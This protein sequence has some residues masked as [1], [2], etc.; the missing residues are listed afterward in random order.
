MSVIFAFMKVS[1]R[2]IAQR[3]IQKIQ[4]EIK[5]DNLKLQ[6]VIISAGNDPNSQTYIRFKKE[7]AEEIGIKAT[8]LSFSENQQ[9]ECLKSIHELNAN[10]TVHGII[11]QLPLYRHW[12]IPAYIHS[13]DPQKDVD[14]FIDH[15]SFFGATALGVWEML[16]EFAAIEGFESTEKFLHGKSVVIVGKGITAGKPTIELLQK[17]GIKTTIIDSKTDH[18][19][20]ILRNSD[21]IISATGRKHI[22]HAENIK[23]GAY[24]IGVGMQKEIID[25]TEKTIG[26]IDPNIDM[27]AKL[28]CPTIGG[29][30][31]LTIACLLRN[32]LEASKLQKN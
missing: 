16:G 4:D 24:V 19:D 31:P 7:K 22:I 6:L 17:K 32:V 25:G 12:D 11:T 26:D 3:I 13:I 5:K 14:G 9:K 20:E 15:S 28:Y 27:K 2:P 30:G 8:I 10:S 23:T 21:V 1:G 18:P 29:I